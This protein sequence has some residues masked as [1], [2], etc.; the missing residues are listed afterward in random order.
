MLLLMMQTWLASLIGEPVWTITLADL[1]GNP[2][3]Q[4]SLANLIGKAF[5]ANAFG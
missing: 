2:L 3:E 4:T 5:L 1:L